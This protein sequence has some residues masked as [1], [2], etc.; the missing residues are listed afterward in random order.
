MTVPNSGDV[1]S[2]SQVSSKIGRVFA[3]RNSPFEFREVEIEITRLAQALKQLAEALHNE[4]DGGLIQQT[5]EQVQ[6]DIGTILNAHKQMIKDLDALVDRNQVTKKHRTVGGFAI[7]RVWSDSVLTEYTSMIWTTEGGDLH[8]LQ[9]LLQTHTNSAT[10]LT[11]ALQRSVFYYFS[12]DGQQQADIDQ[13]VTTSSGECRFLD[14][15]S[16]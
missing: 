6:H 2:L 13:H 10:R 1:L 16:F 8:S 5:A 7:E 11:Q 4:G 3:Q 12:N 15:R 9:S 14:I